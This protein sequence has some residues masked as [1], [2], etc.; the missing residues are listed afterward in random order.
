MLKRNRSWIKEKQE[1]Q[2]VVKNSYQN[3][4]RTADMMFE[5][6]IKLLKEKKL[7]EESVVVLVS[8]HGHSLFDLGNFNNHGN[9]PFKAEAENIIAIKLQKNFLKL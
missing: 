9:L 7:F 1:E 3:A 5:R 8:D 4:V 6:F 2:K